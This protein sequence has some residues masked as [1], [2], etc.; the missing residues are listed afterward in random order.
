[1]RILVT[2]HRGYI[3]AVIAPMIATA[4]HF[5]TG[6]DSALY[7]G[8][9]LGAFDAAFPEIRKDIRDLVPRDL[10]G[11]DAVVHLAGLCNDPL[12][13]LNS[14]LTYE[15][16]H[17]A[18]VDLAR[19]ARDAGASRFVFS[20]SCSTYGAAL[21]GILLD[22]TAAFR[23]VTDY[24]W[25]KVFA[26]RDVAVLAGDGFSPTFLRN[27][28][29]YGMSPRLRLDIVLNDLVGAAL[30]TGRVHLK[31]DG[32]PWR[33][34]VH[35]EDIGNAVLA[36]LDAPRRAVHNQAFNVGAGDEENYQVRDLAQ[37]VCET[38]PGSR[39]E[40]ASD[41]GP[42]RRS[43]RVSFRKIHSRLPGFVPQWNARRGA[44]QLY[45]G[46]K[47]S[48]LTPEQFAGSRYRRVDRV[49]ELLRTAALDPSLRWRRGAP[50]AVRAAGSTAF[51]R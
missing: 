22:E 16:N 40:Y 6:L 1:M 26:E 11:F 31:S 33:P 27:A 8:C 37:I 7:D 41:A 42:D 23:P 38:V 46:Y 12:G 44:Q 47:R 5:V 35:V 28:T 15:I 19:L 39:I 30:T 51:V 36:V 3:G 32:T 43:Y 48:G 24:G 20:S 14:G 49:R 2:G 21:A 13:A 18:T 4:G 17:S 25:S 29:A 50:E 10:D 9:D 45:D 34:I